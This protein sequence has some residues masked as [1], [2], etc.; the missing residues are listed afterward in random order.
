MPVY[1]NFDQE[2]LDREYNTRADVPDFQSFFDRWAADSANV[3]ET[4]G[5]MIDIAYGPGP[6]ERLDVFA[7]EPVA[8]VVVFIHGGYWRA[9]DK[10]YYSFLAPPLNK[11]GISLVAISYPLAP[12][13]TMDE[14]VA[15]VR[16]AFLW[17]WR[18]GADY[19]LDPRRLHAFGHSAGGHLTA[20]AMS[21]DW[22]AIDS[23][24]PADLIKGGFGLSGLYDL[25]PIRLS[26]LNADVR[27]DAAMANRN[28]PIHHVPRA[29]APLVLSVGG[30]ESS[31]FH[32]QQKAY[33]AAW[34]AAGNRAIEIPAPGHNHFTIVDEL[35]VPESALFA[36][37]KGL[38]LN[39]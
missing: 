10:N 20:E 35:A 6:R 11:A 16:R 4:I 5:G 34:R 27:L 12:A 1:R 9:F 26:F 23:G 13:A 18:H 14:I 17:I 15:A 28:S 38:V 21:A 39:P 19:G 30:A 36:A 37:L 25:E 33:A 32:R 3:R 8:P 29:D 31:E 7:V 2:E 24:A 22:P